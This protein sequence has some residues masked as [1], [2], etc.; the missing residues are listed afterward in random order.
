MFVDRTR[1]GRL[2]RRPAIS[3]PNQLPIER[4]Y[5]MKDDE[6]AL[7][8]IVSA[9]EGLGCGPRGCAEKFGECGIMS[10]MGYYDISSMMLITM[11][12][13]VLTPSK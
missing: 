10:I 7:Q 8:G 4:P 2:G 11:R 1:R 9:Q 6:A 12:A 13:G 5:N 3:A